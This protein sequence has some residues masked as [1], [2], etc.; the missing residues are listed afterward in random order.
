M[1]LP[2]GFISLIEASQCA[3]FVL[4]QGGV[5]IVALQQRGVI[6]DMLQSMLQQTGVITITFCYEKI[7]Y[8]I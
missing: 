5:I 4:Q 2:K 1:A 7:G 6:A 8:S 3:Q